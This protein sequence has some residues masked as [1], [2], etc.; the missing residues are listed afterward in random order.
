MSRSLEMSVT[1][2]VPPRVLYDSLLDERDIMK[3][4]RSPARASRDVGGQFSYFNGSIEGENVELIPAEKIVQKWRFNSWQDGVYSTVTLNLKSAGE[5]RC[6]VHLVQ[7]GIPETDKFGNGDVPRK[8]EEGWHQHFWTQISRMLGY[9]L[10][11]SI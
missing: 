2:E 11:D 5:D 8:V 9:Q 4:T 6:T 10:A 1:F 3:F 7:T